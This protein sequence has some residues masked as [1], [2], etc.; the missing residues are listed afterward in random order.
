MKR[1]ATGL[2][3]ALLCA[4][5]ALAQA[6]VARRP[7]APPAAP[8]ASGP[9]VAQGLSTIR[10]TVSQRL[11]AAMNQTRMTVCAAQLQ[12]IVDFLLEGQ[13][14]NFTFQPLG[15]DTNRWPV[16]VTLE[17][18]HPALGRT[19]LATIIASPGQ[20]CSGMY[21]QTIYWAEPCD[22]LKRTTFAGFQSPHPLSREVQVSEANA[23]LQLYLMPAGAG[24][25]SVKK[26]LFH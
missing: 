11:A 3:A 22:T 20:G 23:G 17:S 9:S 24:C 8:L 15:P 25:V 19:R 6:P 26:E 21:Q 5:A 4:P 7:A 14:G 18:S 2:M 12:Q 16:V 1:L 13:D 10:P